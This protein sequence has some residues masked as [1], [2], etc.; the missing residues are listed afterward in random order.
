MVKTSVKIGHFEID[1]AE[2][3]NEIRGEQTLSIPC[4]S[5]PDLCKQLDAW[6]HDSSIPALLNG[7]HSTL[8][9]QRYD[10]NN[11]AWIMRIV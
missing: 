8:Y 9:L 4:N 10:S 6:D 1:D 3:S 5:D 7:E 2:L 11:H